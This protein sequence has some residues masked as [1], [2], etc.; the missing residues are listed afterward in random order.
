MKKG[1]KGTRAL[2]NK[3]GKKQQRTEKNRSGRN[4]HVTTPFVQAHGKFLLKDVVTSFFTQAVCMYCM[5]YH[6]VLYDLDER[7]A[8]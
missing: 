2:I 4:I 3:P 5:H 7:K 8:N 6:T 1:K